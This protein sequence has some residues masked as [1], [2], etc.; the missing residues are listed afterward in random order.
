MVA[1]ART[2]SG[3]QKN[4]PPSAPETSRSPLARRWWLNLA[5]LVLVA[6]LAVF[7]WYRSAHPPGDTRSSLTNVDPQ[8]VRR[9]EI[10]Q[11]KQPTV[12]LERT[13]SGWRMSAPLNAR[14]DG[15]A[16]DNLLRL[17]RAPVETTVGP[18]DSNLARY[19]L[20]SPSLVAR[21]DNTTIRFG[22]MH[23]LK[24]SYYVQHDS[25]VQL[26]SSRYYAQVAAK[27]TNL[28]DTRLIEPGRKVVGFKFP[29]FA[30]TLKDGTWQRQPELPSLSSDRINAFVDDW[31][32]A[33]ALQVDKDAGRKPLEQVVLTF[34]DEPGQV[35]TL[36]LGVVSR[37]GELV[38]VRPDEGLQYHFPEEGGRR[39]FTLEPENPK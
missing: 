12:V 7:A 38:L 6:A 8:T 25:T 10:Q 14:A 18:V 33:R 20:E 26:I 34:E 31:R 5:L 35:T 11:T 37:T 17:A 3:A 16:V 28:I 29:R 2:M 32:H 4:A 36:R 15:L 27:Y 22:A 19:G 13:E 24:D 9:I 30:L 23:P 21:L 39:L 1:P